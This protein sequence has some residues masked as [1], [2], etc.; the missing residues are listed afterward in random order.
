MATWVAAPGGYFA[1]QQLVP[2]VL[3]EYTAVK[4]LAPIASWDA[5]SAMLAEVVLTPVGS[6]VSVESKVDPRMNFTVP[7]GAPPPAG[8]AVRVAV[9][10]VDP[11]DC[12]V[13]DREVS[14]TVSVL[15]AIPLTWYAPM[16]M[17]PLLMR[18]CPRKS[19][20]P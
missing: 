16:L 11:P 10:V 18:G 9:S 1:L 15:L 4:V 14:F 3:P 7:L 12:R 2:I 20:A 6:R 19:V 8:L 17:A 5:L 13:D